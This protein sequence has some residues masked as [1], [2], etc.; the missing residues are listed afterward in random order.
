[1]TQSLSPSS[2]PPHLLIAETLRDRIFRGVWH[3]GDAIPTLDQFASEINVARVAARQA[4][5]L[6]I[7]ELKLCA[8]DLSPRQREFFSDIP[9]RS[10]G[11]FH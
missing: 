10:S 4:E 2:V 6:L 9:N 11:L 8:H 3:T 1:M 7:A 5:Q